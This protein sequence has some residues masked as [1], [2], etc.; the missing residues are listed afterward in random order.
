MTK[1][2]LLAFHGV[3]LSASLLLT[4]CQQETPVNRTPLPPVANAPY[5]CDHIPLDAV[6]L[7]T[8]VN[9][10]IVT[11]NFDLT[12]GNWGSGNCFAYQRTGS[13]PRVLDVNL[14][15]AGSKQEVEYR[16]QRGAKRLPDMVPG[17]AGF[18]FQD[19]SADN[20]QAIAV[21]MRDNDRL[22]VELVRGV[23][24]RDNAAD[25]VALMRL[26]APKLLPA[27]KAKG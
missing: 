4:A 12:S 7:M 23:K 15:P 26:V 13:R 27:K 5:I 25:V 14:S 6:R 18:Y 10:P 21:L 20:T 8:G 3:I 22:I 17:A 11:G 16:I 19:G 2:A 1:K 9:E 24:G